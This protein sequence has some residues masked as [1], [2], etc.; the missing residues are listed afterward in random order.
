MTKHF[1]YCDCGCKGYSANLGDVGFW[2]YWDLGTVFMLYRGHGFL[3]TNLGKFESL[4]KAEDFALDSLTRDM[5]VPPPNVWKVIEGMGDAV[6][7]KTQAEA[8]AYAEGVAEGV[9]L[10]DGEVEI[11]VE[12]PNG[13]VI[14]RN[15]RRV[16]KN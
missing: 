8:R 13:N 12:D 14:W 4:E 6:E 7:W 3:G 9:N 1:K 11:R 5:V 2:I 15:L 16:L 10:C